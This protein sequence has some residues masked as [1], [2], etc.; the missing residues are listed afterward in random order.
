M[1]TVTVM[2]VCL[3]HHG[4]HKFDFFSR[5][6]RGTWLAKRICKRGRF[7]KCIEDLMSQCF[8]NAEFLLTLCL[9]VLSADESSGLIRV[10]TV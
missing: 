4:S 3:S 1:F 6:S 8:C 2:F 10:Q 9:P 5:C 7:Y